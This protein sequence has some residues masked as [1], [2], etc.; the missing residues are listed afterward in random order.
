MT[1]VSILGRANLTPQLLEFFLLNFKLSICLLFS[2]EYSVHLF[3]D[4][5]FLASPLFSHLLNE[6]FLLLLGLPLDRSDLLFSL[7]DLAFK[8]LV[9]D[10][11]TLTFARS[12]RQLCLEVLVLDEDSLGCPPL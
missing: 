5:R 3:A 11:K 7:R 6:L 10:E 4:D 12:R 1:L 2:S 9:F 8:F